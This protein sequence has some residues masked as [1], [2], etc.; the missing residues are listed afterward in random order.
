MIRVQLI[1]AKAHLGLYL[2][3]FLALLEIFLSIVTCFKAL[4]EFGLKLVSIVI[5]DE[6][7]VFSD[8]DLDAYLETDVSEQRNLIIGVLQAQHLVLILWQLVLVSFA[9]NVS[10]S[11]IELFR[12]LFQNLRHFNNNQAFSYCLVFKQVVNREV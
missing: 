9:S 11:I 5:E 7:L 3:L 2:E 6:V 1:L 4:L 12:L 10:E 8:I